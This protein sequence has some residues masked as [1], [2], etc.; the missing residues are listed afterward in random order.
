MK[1]I[2]REMYLSVEL[3]YLASRIIRNIR[4]DVWIGAVILYLDK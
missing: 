4:L 3:S 2:G 1:S